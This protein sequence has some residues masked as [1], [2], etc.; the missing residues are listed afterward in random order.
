MLGICF[1]LGVLSSIIWWLLCSLKY[2]GFYFLS[3]GTMIYNPVLSFTLP[4]HVTVPKYV[5][6]HA[7]MGW[8]NLEAWGRGKGKYFPL[9]HNKLLDSWWISLDTFSDSLA[10]CM[11]NERKGVCW[12]APGMGIAFESM[13][14]TPEAT[15]FCFWHI[16][17]PG[18]QMLIRMW[19]DQA[20]KTVS[21]GI[22]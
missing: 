9:I 11:T 12:L 22:A 6:L 18:K 13:P 3:L 10:W 8:G 16:P 4:Q 2:G 15:L 14:T 7:M 17:G 21:T 19:K 20:L 5:A 1:H